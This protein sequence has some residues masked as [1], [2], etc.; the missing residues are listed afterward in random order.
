MITSKE[1]RSVPLF[2]HLS[3]EVA[4]R[5]AAHCADLHITAGEVI[6]HED[7]APV[8]F[9]ILDGMVD[10]T[11]I[12]EGHKRHMATRHPGDFFGEIPVMLQTSYLVTA[13]AIEP[14]RLLRLDASD[15][16][17]LAREDETIR[18]R[19]TDVIT[20]RV[21]GVAEETIDVVTR[22]PIVVGTPA[23][24]SCFN[25]REFLTRNSIP[26]EWIDPDD[27]GWRDRLPESVR[28][29]QEH[30]FV[31]FPQEDGPT[32]VISEPTIRQLAEAL[33]MPTRP[34]HEAYDVA[35][36]G[37]G[38]AGLAAA[39]YGASEGLST[40]MIERS[41]PGGQA[42]SSSRIENYLGFPAGLSGD[43]LAKRAYNQAD[44]LGAEI[45]IARDVQSIETGDERRLILDDGESI[46]VKCVVLSMG[47]SYRRLD[48]DNC[49]SFIGAGV[50][51]GAA[52]TEALSTVGQDVF[53]V[54]GGNSAGQAAMFFANYAKNVTL[55]V[56]G[57]DLAATMSQYLIDELGKR[58]N[59]HLRPCSEVVGM[60]GN[61]SLESIRVR[62][63]DS[64]E[65]ET[66]PARAIFIFIG[67]EPKTEWLP[68]SIARDKWG[69]VL[70]GVDVPADRWPIERNPYLLETSVPGIFS[71]G[72]VRHGSIKRVA[73]GVGEGSMS[74]AFV[75]QYLAQTKT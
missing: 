30:P 32:T 6:V 62:N 19:I 2:A 54:G 73:A 64:S 4:A 22:L 41:V 63:C 65:E 40:I 47:V 51:Y 15:F 46:R 23:D 66:L 45:L 18:K 11:K 69:F 74:I 55:L 68:D 50:Y 57:P 21:A 49:D 56:R 5:Y 53:L 59:V 71:A 24:L 3:D 29:H 1:L 20:E 42:G 25:I 70:T 8:F 28:S 13:T 33:D 10:L 38:P 58:S 14:T 75:H 26:F 16:A 36:I 34:K 43:D 52:R 60:S 39:V 44:R 27:A 61:G 67:A 12:V 37:G 17:R 31:A 7:E 9:A 72:D 35:I 48:I